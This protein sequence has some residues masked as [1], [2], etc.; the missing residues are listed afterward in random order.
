MWREVSDKPNP[1]PRRWFLVCN[2]EKKRQDVALFLPQGKGC[3]MGHT[4]QFDDVTHWQELPEL[5]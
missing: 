1:E 3:F 5:P 2:K 4:L